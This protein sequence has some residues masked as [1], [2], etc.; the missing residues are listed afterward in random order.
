[1]PRI[2]GQRGDPIPSFPALR[3]PQGRLLL[4]RRQVQ[5]AVHQ[6]RRGRRVLQA[7]VLHQEAELEERE[8]DA[9]V[10]EQVGLAGGRGGAAGRG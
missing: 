6:R 5:V 10:L 8:E 1:M 3:P 7:V 4:L 2:S 9:A